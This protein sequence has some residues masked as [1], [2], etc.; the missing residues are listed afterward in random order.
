MDSGAWVMSFEAT[1]CQDSRLVAAHVMRM[2]H[3]QNIGRAPQRAL[4][5]GPRETSSGFRVPQQPP[6][7]C[8]KTAP[9]KKQ[10]RAP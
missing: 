4:E 7:A 6:V 10:K 3:G 5:Q 9:P 2:S 8:L 1:N